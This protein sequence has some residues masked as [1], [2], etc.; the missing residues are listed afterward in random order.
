[1][2]TNKKTGEITGP[3]QVAIAIKYV[4]KHIDHLPNPTSPHSK[5]VLDE[6]LV[7]LEYHVADLNL[8]QF[9]HLLKKIS[10]KGYCSATKFKCCMLLAHH[11]QFQ[12]F[13]TMRPTSTVMPI[14]QRNS[15]RR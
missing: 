14:L 4:L 13:L 10:V 2:L 1:M 6:P 15:T 5:A 12:K 3:H 11:I 8:D 9:R 7:Y